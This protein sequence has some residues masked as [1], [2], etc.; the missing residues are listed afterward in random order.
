MGSLLPLS[1]KTVIN[2]IPEVLEDAENGLP[3]F[4]SALI[5]RLLE[6][7]KLVIPTSTLCAQNRAI[8]DSSRY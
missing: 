5:Q 7:L 3:S 2:K 4:F 8:F 6:H 1:V